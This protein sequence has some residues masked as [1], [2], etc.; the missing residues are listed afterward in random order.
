[1]PVGAAAIGAR[2]FEGL[3]APH[4]IVL[5]AIATRLVGIDDAADVWIVAVSAGDRLIVR[6]TRNHGQQWRAI[7]PPTLRV[8]GGP[9]I[10]AINCRHALLDV[11][12]LHGAERLY[13][14]TDAGT[15]WNLI[16]PRAIR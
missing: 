10:S 16:D 14:T 15:T 7:R 8:E 2:E 9:Q 12:N 4:A 11:R 1:M 6:T 5:T 3:V 13:L